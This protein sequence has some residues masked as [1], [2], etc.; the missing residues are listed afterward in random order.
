MNA[1]NFY[2]EKEVS[3]RTLYQGNKTRN[4][5]NFIKAVL[6]KQF[7]GEKKRILDLGCGQGGDLLK[8][9]YS[10]PSLY[11]GID[12]SAKA[13]ACAQTRA[14]TIKLNCRN[15]FLCTNFTKHH[16]E[17]YPP[18]DVINCQFAIQFAFK[19]ESEA[20]FTFE[21]ISRFLVEDG[22]FIGT[23]PKHDANTYDEVEVQLPDDD[24]KCKEYA[25]S[26][27]DLTN[28]CK[29]YDL[30]LVLL[31]NF[32]TFFKHA[33]ETNESLSKKMNVTE[34]PDPLNLV[35]SFQKRTTHCA[36]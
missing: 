24:R 36:T 30:H 32:D 33:K 2:D 26:A 15:H 14:S 1:Q 18:Y 29:K 20:N 3:H 7:V 16:W 4:S 11:V 27:E 23:V 21:K 6:I 28:M 19:T 17:G 5:H 31:E 8:I 12:I 22:F 9:K 13:I 34:I 10:C 25:V 35:F